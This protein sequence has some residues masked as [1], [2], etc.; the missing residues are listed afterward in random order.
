MPVRGW[1]L[2]CCVFQP[3]AARVGEEDHCRGGGRLPGAGH[4]RPQHRQ[5]E[6][7][8][9]PP[10]AAHLQLTAH[11]AEGESDPPHIEQKVSQLTAH[12]AGEIDLPHIEQD[13][14]ST[15]R[16]FNRM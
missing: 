2:G 12:R 13:V 5:A 10:A 9:L 1:L 8:A 16:T 4:R 3:P 14:R 11:R 6:E 15:H 7:P